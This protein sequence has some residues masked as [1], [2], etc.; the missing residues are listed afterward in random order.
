MSSISSSN[1]SD[2][3]ANEESTISRRGVRAPTVDGGRRPAR[4][5]RSRPCRPPTRDHV[6]DL[7]FDQ[8]CLKKTGIPTKDRQDRDIGDFCYH[9]FTSDNDENNNLLEEHVLEQFEE[10]SS[11]REFEDDDKKKQQ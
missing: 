6:E 10:I 8:V 1:D 3:G 2:N 11:S 4:R 9:L 5:S 7:S